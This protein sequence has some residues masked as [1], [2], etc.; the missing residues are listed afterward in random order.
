MVTGTA[1]SA[2][3]INVTPAYAPNG[4]SSM[5]SFSAWVQ[6][7]IPA[8]E[9]GDLAA[10]PRLAPED[11]EVTGPVVPANEMVV[12]TFPS[13]R[14][15]A[16]PA[17][18]FDT[19]TGNRVHFGLHIWSTDPADPQFS[20]QD[21]FYEIDSNDP[22]DTFDFPEA[23]DPLPALS[24]DYRASLVGIDYVDGIKG[25]GDDVRYDG[26][27]PASGDT[28]VNE[29]IYV[30]VG[31]AY[32]AS[33]F[34]GATNQEKIDNLLAEIDFA[35]FTLAAAYQLVLGDA[36]MGQGSGSVSVVAI[37]EPATLSLL[38]LPMLGLMGWVRRRR[39]V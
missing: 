9:A 1:R 32:D 3:Q 12:T 11:Y 29:I 28:L 22:P 15:V 8:I 4:A 20:L 30:G 5:A 31:T 24:G 34:S 18:P 7:A 37:P 35:P 25:N 23:G 36:V 16:N 27:N 21:I 17:A 26:S 19:Q 13:W 33:S 38:G 14:G 6:N 39:R 2:I 10:G